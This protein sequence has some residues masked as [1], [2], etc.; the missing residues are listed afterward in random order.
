M[1][2]QIK[3]L[4]LTNARL[5]HLSRRRVTEVAEQCRWTIGEERLIVN[6]KEKKLHTRLKKCVSGEEIFRLNTNLSLKKLYKTFHP[7]YY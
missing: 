2:L 3:N 5:Q 7:L 1:K 4:K 6:S